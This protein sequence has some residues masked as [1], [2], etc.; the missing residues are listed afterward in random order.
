MNSSHTHRADLA[1]AL[2]QLC[3]AAA[4]GTSWTGITDG[5]LTDWERLTE[6]A[7]QHGLVAFL[8]TQH[9]QYHRLSVPPD[10]VARWRD[11]YRAQLI[12]NAC[13]MH[14]IRQ[15]ATACTAQGTELVLLKGCA[16]LLWLYEDRGL[17]V[18][19]DLDILVPPG[20]AEVTFELLVELGYQPTC[21]A[22]TRKSAEE[23]YLAEQR[24]LHLPQMARERQ[25]PIELHLRLLRQADGTPFLPD[26]WSDTISPDV[27]LPHLKVLSP[28]HS[29][30]HGSIHY[31]KHLHEGFCPLKSLLDLLLIVHEHGHELDWQQLWVTARRWGILTEAATVLATLKRVWSLP[32]PGLQKGTNALSKDELIFGRQPAPEAGTWKMNWDYLARAKQLKGLPARARYLLRAFFPEPE[33]LRDQFHLP[34]DHPLIGAYFRYSCSGIL[35]AASQLGRAPSPT[36][37]GP[38]APGQRLPRDRGAP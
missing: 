21:K 16:A 25:V 19:G 1:D 17:R 9:S 34:P 14:Q 26:L 24:R 12:R 36:R 22:V 20:Q 31:W 28:T 37:Q 2:L 5:D 10:L 6:L 13:G 3:H 8:Y 11:H 15:L 18:L 29:L 33:Y 35:R 27:N 7:D 38:T 32:I 4:L 30:L 23:A